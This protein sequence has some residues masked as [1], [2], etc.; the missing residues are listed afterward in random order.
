MTNNLF[1]QFACSFFIAWRATESDRCGTIQSE[2]SCFLAG[3]YQ[4]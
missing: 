4:H 1:K 3:T 2:W